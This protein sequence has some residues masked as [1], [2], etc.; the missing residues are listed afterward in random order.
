MHLC[1]EAGAEV[2]F[3]AFVDS[4]IKV[5]ARR[6]EGQNSQAAGAFVWLRAIGLLVHDP[7]LETSVW[8]SRAVPPMTGNAV[9][10]G[11]G[12]PAATTTV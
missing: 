3:G 2:C 12:P 8:P 5:G 11:T 4:L 9:A 6:I 1:D 10:A 7:L